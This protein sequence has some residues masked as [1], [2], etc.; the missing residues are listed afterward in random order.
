MEKEFDIFQLTLHP[1]NPRE[2]SEFMEGKLIE[3]ILVFPHMLQLRP[4]LVNKSNVVVGG[5]Q[6]VS[7]LQQIVRMD[8]NEIED[9]LFNQ[10]KFRLMSEEGKVELI[11][12]WKEWKKKPVV[13][14][15]VLT[16]LTESEEKELLVKDNIHYGEDDIDA[17]KQHFDRESYN[18]YFG[19]VPWNLY[20]YNDK[21]NDQGL[22]MPTK[23]PEKFKCGY[24][25]CQLTDREF[26]DI[27]ALFERYLEEHEGVG[28]GFLTLLLLE[29]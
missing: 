23:F 9:Y 20:D 3:S 11:N 21:I 8:D 6:R 13:P 2:M 25:E 15:R 26:T 18:D 28:D 10:K 4:I 1:Q 22:E 19:S 27:C 14:A 16:N 24:V 7:C 5:N 17:L 12:Y 29:Q